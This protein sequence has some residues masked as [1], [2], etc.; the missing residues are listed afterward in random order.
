MPGH[1]CAVGART[2]SA[3]KLFVPLFAETPLLESGTVTS[4]ENL[5][6]KIIS[7]R[8]DLTLV[9]LPLQFALPRS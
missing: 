4:A 6:P 5:S 1:G 7:D 2:E 9:S 8:I 3:W